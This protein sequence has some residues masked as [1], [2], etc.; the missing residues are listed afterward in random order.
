MP[1]AVSFAAR[2]AFAAWLRNEKMPDLIYFSDDYLCAGALAAFAVARVRVPHSNILWRT[3]PGS[4]FEVPV[5][6]PAGASSATLLVTGNGYSREY[7]GL[8]D[9]MFSLSLPAADS[10]DAENI[11]DLTLTF[12][13]ALATTRRAKL[14]VVQG[15]HTGGEANAEVR[16]E[17]SSSWSNVRKK[18][19]L[20]ILS[21]VDAVSVD[22]QSV[23]A[24]LWQSPGWF[25]L[26][27]RSGTAYDVLLSSGG[28]MLT[29]AILQGLASGFT[30][31]VR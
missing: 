25:L 16:T 8:A 21:G 5:F 27:A 6:M 31:F 23:D 26:L 20:P 15:A 24:S 3:A 12:N 4:D 19:V 13:D 29:G 28:S 17:G 30:L 7:T 11:Y 14:A 10:A 18:A 2:D 1:M 22:G 9:G